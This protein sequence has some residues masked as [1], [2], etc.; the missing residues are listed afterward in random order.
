MTNGSERTGDEGCLLQAT[1]LF[2]N[3]SVSFYKVNPSEPETLYGGLNQMQ[4]VLELLPC[5]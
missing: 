3:Q 5:D 1:G 2:S 4:S